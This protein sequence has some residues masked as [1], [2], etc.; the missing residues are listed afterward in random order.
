M[1]V[2]YAKKT[3]F[4]QSGNAVY[5]LTEFLGDR[6]SDLVIA[7]GFGN[8]LV[9]IFKLDDL[10]KRFD[11]KMARYEVHYRSLSASVE[12]PESYTLVTSTENTYWLR[13]E[14]KEII[15]SVRENK[16]VN[17]FNTLSIL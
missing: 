6:Y 7:Q 10:F 16:E 2:E 3:N 12:E 1:N 8:H 15:D 13:K 9:M 11:G 14:L 5:D 4:E 17:I